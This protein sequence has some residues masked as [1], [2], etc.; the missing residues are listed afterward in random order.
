MKLK[1]TGKPH[2]YMVVSFLGWNFDE[3][4]FKALKSRAALD[5]RERKRIGIT[6]LQ[7]NIWK[8]PLPVTAEY[9]IREFKPDV[10]GAEFIDTVNL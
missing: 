6:T 8:I 1:S 9:R 3:D 4:L 2:H 7:A 10:E 5:A